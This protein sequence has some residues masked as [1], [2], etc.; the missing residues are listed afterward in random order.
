MQQNSV[1]Y[2][3]VLSIE[4]VESL[5]RMA[6]RKEIPSVNYGIRQALDQYLANEKRTRYEREMQMAAQDEA[7]MS[8]TLG[9]QDAFAEIDAEEMSE[10]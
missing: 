6:N 10:W 4:Q 7:F 9:T 8:R 1:K 5:K 2:T 3:A